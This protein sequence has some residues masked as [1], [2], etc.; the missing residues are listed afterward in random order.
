LL[1]AKTLENVIAAPASMGLSRL[2]AARGRAAM[3]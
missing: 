2:A 3:L 1:T